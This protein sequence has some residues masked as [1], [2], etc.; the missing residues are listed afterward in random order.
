MRWGKRKGLILFEPGRRPLR[1]GEPHR[2]VRGSARGCS[3]S[4]SVRWRPVRR[5]V[6]RQVPPKVG[7]SPT[8]PGESLNTAMVP[9]DEWSEEHMDLLQSRPVSGP[10]DVPRSR[11]GLAPPH[12]NG[13]GAGNGTRMSRAGPA[14]RGA[15]Q[16][17]PRRH[18][19]P[20]AAGPGGR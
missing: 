12:P 16:R 17:D 18:L 2:T 20:G 15:G 8:G 3:P 1:F 7:Y 6:Y 19:R 4:T 5:E 14:F 9:L 10:A 11:R 13:P